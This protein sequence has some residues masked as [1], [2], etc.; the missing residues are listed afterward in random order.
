MTKITR[1][2]IRIRQ[3]KRD[4]FLTYLTVRDLKQENFYHVDRLD[5]TN[6]TGITGMQR[7]LNETRARSFA[8]DIVGAN[9]E[10]EAFLPTSIFLATKEK[11]SYS[12][13]TKELSFDTDVIGHF[14]VVDGQHRIRGLEFAADKDPGFIDFPIS[15]VIAHDLTE[16]EMM[17]QFVTVNTKQEPVH[18]GVKQGIIAKFHRMHRIKPVPYMPNWLRNKV[19]SG[20]DDEALEIAKAL[21]LRDN[22]PWYSL[23]DLT[24]GEEK[25]REDKKGNTIKQATF[26]KSVKRHLLARNHPY[27]DGALAN[28]FNKKM[29]ILRNYWQAIRNIFVDDE[30]D[31]N[32][33]PL[34]NT[35][36]FKYT[37]LEF[38][39]RVSSPVFQILARRR[40]YQVETI[41]NCIRSASEHLG[42]NIEMMHPDYWKVGGKASELNAAAIGRLAA[43][44]KAA[45]NQAYGDDAKI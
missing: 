39:H 7:L 9:E 28:N 17:L 30:T 42:G 34:L 3:G 37:G 12:D 16:E 26:V 20:H 1:P 6:P 45:L 21:S 25:S 32:P 43:E 29:D 36:V 27:V 10:D 23:V 31:E 18:D 8:K 11:L 14:D 4:L 19:E 44:F 41:E 24:S 35:V 2:A 15:T 22:S 5:V 33:K 38:F 13:A 40:E